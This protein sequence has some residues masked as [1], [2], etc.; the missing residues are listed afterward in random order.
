M[1]A[2]ATEVATLSRYLHDVFQPY[3][4]PAWV[5]IHDRRSEGLWLFESG[6][7][8]SVFNWYRDHLVTEPSGGTAENCVSFSSDDG[9]WWDNDCERRM[10]YVCEYRL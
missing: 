6:Q 5:G 2:D 10:Y 8:V 9:K 7:R 3:N 1:P 4:W